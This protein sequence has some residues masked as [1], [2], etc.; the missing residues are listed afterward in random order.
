MAN[1]YWRIT[2]KEYRRLSNEFE[3]EGLKAQK[4]VMSRCERERE[5]NAGERCHA[6]GRGDVSRECKAMHEENFPSSWLR[7][8]LVGKEERRKED[9]KIREEVERKEKRKKEEK[10]EEEEKR[11]RNGDFFFEGVS[12]LFRLRLL[13]F[14]VKGRLGELRISRRDLLEDPGDSLDCGGLGWRGL[15]CLL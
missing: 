2:R 10:R 12:I 14:F 6:Q 7:E 3:M 8:D 11:D 4:D 9:K 1:R 13:T 15:W 5:K